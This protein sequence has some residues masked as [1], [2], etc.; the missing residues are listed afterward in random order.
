MTDLVT[1]A[2][3]IVAGD[4]SN[5]A[6]MEQAL[7]DA[8]KGAHA[9]HMDMR[10]GVA[11]YIISAPRSPSP[12]PVFRAAAEAFPGWVLTGKRSVGLV[13]IMTGSIPRLH[14]WKYQPVE[15]VPA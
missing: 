11:G 7:L 9:V 4:D 6:L 12:A 3:Q 5:A 1:L 2:K 10:S 13:Q 15:A 14:V 8:G